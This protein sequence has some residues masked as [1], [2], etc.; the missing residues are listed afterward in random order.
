MSGLDFVLVSIF[1]AFFTAYFVCL[2]H[3]DEHKIVIRRP[4]TFHTQDEQS[5]IHLSAFANE[6]YWDHAN[7]VTVAL[8][9]LF[10]TL[11]III[12]FIFCRL[13][14]SGLCGVVSLVSL[15]FL[16]QDHSMSFCIYYKGAKTSK[17][18]ASVWQGM[19]V[20][21]IKFLVMEELPFLYHAISFCHSSC[22]TQITGDGRIAILKPLNSFFHSSCFT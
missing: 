8:Y 18:H 4:L 2:C 9:S 11:W 22:F 6:F 13:C 1:L 17:E 21:E 20:C 5:F 15:Y 14:L 19:C 7:W 3:D 12:I 10:H 16:W